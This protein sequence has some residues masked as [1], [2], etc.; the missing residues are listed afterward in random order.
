MG[1]RLANP[2]VL[3]KKNSA[4]V[5]PLPEHRRWLSKQTPKPPGHHSW[6]VD[7]ELATAWLA[8]SNRPCTNVRVH[9]LSPPAPPATAS[10]IA[11]AS[12][13]SKFRTTANLGFLLFL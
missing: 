3:S 4:D 7:E 6:G 1:P 10:D 13:R 5:H 2:R 12:S 9:A 11:G 8:S